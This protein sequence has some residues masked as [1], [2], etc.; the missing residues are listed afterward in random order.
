MD[1]A[2][3]LGFLFAVG[4]IAFAM[5][6]GTEGQFKVFYS[7]EGF[8]LVMGGAI[9]LAIMSMPFHATKSLPA[10]LKKCI[11]HK[12]VEPKH[13][14]QQIVQFA[15]TARRDGVLALASAVKSTNA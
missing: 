1:I 12:D 4:A 7:Q 15:E 13:L 8:M 6:E 3:I 9:G 2:T 10:Y 14:I 5:Y 11:F